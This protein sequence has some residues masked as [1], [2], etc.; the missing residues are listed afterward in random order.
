V[1]PRG[2]ATVLEQLRSKAPGY[3]TGFVP[4]FG[5]AGDTLFQVLAEFA[6]LVIER[7]NKAPDKDFLAF[8]DAMGVTLLP[9]RAARVPLVF[10]V[11]PSA[12]TDVL[13]PAGTEVA[14]DLP[15]PLPSSLKAGQTVGP[16]ATAA[17]PLIFATDEAV[18]LT[19]AKLSSVLS[20]LPE[21]VADHTASLSTGFSL[22]T[23]LSQVTHELYLG[24]DTLFE[25]PV[26]ATVTLVFATSTL[27]N[28][29]TNAVGLSLIW[30]YLTADGWIQFDPQLD[31]T[32]G[33][34]TDGDV[35]LGK[36]CGPPLKKTAIN[37]VQSFWIRARVFKP[38]PFPGSAS[39]DV[40]LP[41]IDTIGARVAY[42]AGDLA[43]EAASANGFKLDTSKDFQPFGAQPAVSS[44]F[45]FACDEAFKRSGVKCALELKLSAVG[46]VGKDANGHPKKLVIAW[47]YSI[48]PGVWGSLR[49]S[50]NTKNFTAQPAPSSEA[51]TFSRPEDWQKTSIDGDSHWW[52]RARVASGDYGG[53]TTYGISGTTAKP[54][55]V[56]TPPMLSTLKV[57][58]TI[59]TAFAPDHCMAL[60][61]FSFADYSEASRWGR[62]AFQ[63]FQPTA[64]RQGAVYFGFD[65]QPP[66]G[67]V[68]LYADIPNPGEIGSVGGTSLYTWEY[69]SS[70]GWSELAVHD[71][72]LGFQQS[73]M[74]QF[75][76]P[77]D[78]IPDSGPAQALYWVRAR[79]LTP[80]DPTSQQI[81]LLLLNAVWA[82]Q[83]RSVVGEI[84]G[85]SEGSAHLALTLQHA[86]VLGGEKVE[87]QE[88]RGSTREWESLFRTLP[89]DF[90]RK[91]LDA[92]GNV[93]GLW[94]T[95]EERPHLYSSRPAD[96][97]Y[98]L[99]RT[100]GLLRFGNGVQGMV[101]PP[102]APVAVSYEYGGGTSGNVPAG[103]V[104]QLHSGVP[105]V[106]AVS[107]PIPAG[108]GAGV[109]AETAVLVR[110]PEHL[111]NR[112]RAVSPEDY[113]WL[114]REASTEVAVARCLPETGPAGPGQPG[115]VTMVIAPWSDDPAP[116]PSVELMRQ[117]REYLAQRAPAA[118]ATQIRIT[119]PSYVSVSVFTEVTISDAGQCAAVE[120]ALRSALDAYL[121]PLKGGPNGTGWRFGQ[122]VHLSQ[123]ATVIRGVAGVDF[124]DATQL[125]SDGIIYG[126]FVPVPAERL[127]APGR[128]LLKLRLDA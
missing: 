13:L 20:R 85:R 92:R 40:P 107:N 72:T 86:P 45:L 125:S 30:E 99:E 43:L 80:A 15:P 57:S 24:H 68:S 18:S 75:I 84:A 59:S 90:Q 89:P 42:T 121:H 7:L 101:P 16:T 26:D 31:K 49:V 55:N 21:H 95:W 4:T 34:S 76:G 44:S 73:G 124:A 98:T 17:G 38:L 19:R 22:F 46:E 120:E 79:H 47:E 58:Y 102:G 66:V 65:R 97:H 41:Q 60:N 1:D 64:D 67:L 11:A 71:E 52:I 114:A 78:L 8:L 88:W 37:G 74:I 48:G 39:P 104:S 27:H 100:S 25:L 93:T 12:P 28:L 10:S 109:E 33:L 123:I 127:P 77:P 81:N 36:V 113:E 23:G 106:Q 61:A 56:P 122:A 108:G 117:V 70:E 126:D 63:P 3:L 50:D 91:D 87:I 14:A 32:R 118:M 35:T 111:R 128:H 2:A 62:Q 5:G 29:A 96:R 112:D 83:R 6:G 82:T 94:V 9:P 69:R 54:Q 116:V 53:P 51:I 103:T 119:R 115:W 105:S 110:G